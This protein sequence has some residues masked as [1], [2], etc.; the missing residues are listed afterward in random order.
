MILSEYLEELGECLE[1]LDEYIEKLNQ[2]QI[3]LDEINRNATSTRCL[4]SNKTGFLSNA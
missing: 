3:V 2:Y 4:P 1:K